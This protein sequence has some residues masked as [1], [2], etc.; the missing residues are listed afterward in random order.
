MKMKY[1]LSIVLVLFALASCQN[2]GKTGGEN[3]DTDSSATDTSSTAM[4]GVYKAGEEITEDNAMSL[5]EAYT[6]FGEDSMKTMK[7]T[8]TINKVCQ[9]KGCWMTMDLPDSNSMRVKFK[10]YGFFVP[11]DCSG[12]TAVMEGVMKKEVVSIADQKH[13]LEDE[14]A[15]ST[16]IAAVTEDKVEYAFEASGVLIK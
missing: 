4:N 3:H 8:G 2:A 14:G 10:D 11:L 16:A 7:I 12:K 13:L 1:S 9:V 6:S 5:A 15:D